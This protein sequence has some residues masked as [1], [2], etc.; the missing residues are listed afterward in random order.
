MELVRKSFTS[1]SRTR[2]AFELHRF[3]HTVTSRVYPAGH[4]AQVGVPAASRAGPD[5]G[6]G[7]SGFGRHVHHG[8]NGGLRREALHAAYHRSSFPGS[9]CTL[10][11][12]GVLCKI[13]FQGS[14]KPDAETLIKFETQNPCIPFRGSL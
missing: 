1:G 14:L 10:S 13:P 6:V 4:A 5:K 12:P 8:P 11:W 7:R 9:R 3:D 2:R